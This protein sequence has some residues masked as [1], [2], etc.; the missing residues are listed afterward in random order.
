M[1]SMLELGIPIERIFIDK[2]SGKDFARPAWKRLVRKLKRGDTVYV[3]S[4]DRLGRNY[5]DIKNWWQALTKGKGVDIVVLDMPLLDT[6]KGKDVLGTLI[7]DL[8]LSLLSYCAQNEREIIA[9][10]QAEGIAAA[11]QRGVRFGRPAKKLPKNF[12][13]MVKLWEAGELGIKEFAQAAKISEATLY[14]HL[15][16]HGATRRYSALDTDP[17]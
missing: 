11:K 8:V 3:G 2:A 17:T 13:E 5:E 7:A 15:R 16:A 12:G 14:R 1:I 10:R 6:R 9:R 4:I